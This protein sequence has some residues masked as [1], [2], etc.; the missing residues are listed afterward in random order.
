L[1][2]EACFICAA[3]ITKRPENIVCANI[4]GLTFNKPGNKG[5]VVYI[6]TFVSKVGR[7]SITVYGKITINDSET[8]VSD[9]FITFVFVDEDG[10]SIPHNIIM[11]KTDDITELDIRERAKLLSK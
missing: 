5:D 11:D 2:V 9:G 4:H 1:F 3:K 6:Q 7:S 8:L 10:K